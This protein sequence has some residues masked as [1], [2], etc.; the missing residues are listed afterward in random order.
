MPLLKTLIGLPVLIVILVFAFVNND[1]ATFS[2]WPFAFEV[3]VSLSVAVVFFIL[4]GFFLGHLFSWMSY[5]PVRKA[6]RQHKKQC[7]KLN[8]EQQRLVR[9]M[10]DLHED[11]ENIKAKEALLPKPSFKEKL[12]NWFKSEQNESSEK[13]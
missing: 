7:K 2:L 8:K 9:E 3:T 4:L 1:L 11:L 13:N 5:A 10:E 6:L 12:K